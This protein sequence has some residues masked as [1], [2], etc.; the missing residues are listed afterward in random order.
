MRLKD[1]NHDGRRFE[2]VL[3]DVETCADYYGAILGYSEADDRAVWYSAEIEEVG[4][5]QVSQQYWLP[6]G[7]FRTK[8]LRG[9]W[10]FVVEYPETPPVRHEYTLRYDTSVQR[11]S[12]S[13]ITVPAN[14]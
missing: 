5:G 10:R 8:P 3:W 14:R 7:F 6:L 13:E 1:L 9:V 2:F 4:S 12:G 11:F